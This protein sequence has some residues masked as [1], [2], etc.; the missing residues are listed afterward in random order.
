M[1][2]S[3]IF[4][5]KIYEDVFHSSPHKFD[6]FRN[7]AA[8]GEGGHSFGYG[9]YFADSREVANWYK[10]QFLRRYGKNYIYKVNIPD[11]NDYL[12]WNSKLSEQ[13]PKIQKIVKSSYQFVVGKIIFDRK[14]Y[15]NH[16]TKQMQPNFRW[17]LYRSKTLITQSSKDTEEK[18]KADAYDKVTSKSEFMNWTGEHYYNELTKAFAYKDVGWVPVGSQYQRNASEYLS[19]KGV[20]GIKYYNGVRD[21][22]NYVI[23]D[24]KNIVM[25]NIEDIVEGTELIDDSDYIPMALWCI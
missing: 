5:N 20:I 14:D 25:N 7:S 22:Y 9:L 18:A 2:I 16:I 1:R 17:F 3:E 13:S 19:R 8:S 21:G 4:N 12:L 15:M 24:S 6:T 10:A 11:G 23:F